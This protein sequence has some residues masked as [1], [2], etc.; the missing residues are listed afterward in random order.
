MDQTIPEPLP[1]V[2]NRSSCHPFTAHTSSMAQ[3]TARPSKGKNL[4]WWLSAGSP[5]PCRPVV[6]HCSTDGEG[7][8]LRLSLCTLGLTRN[9]I[10]T[11]S[12]AGKKEVMGARGEIWASR[13]KRI[14]LPATSPL[15]FLVHEAA[16]NHCSS[17]PPEACLLLQQQG[18]SIR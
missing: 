14:A 12:K 4:W 9:T 6:Y 13:S 10:G 18:V 2:R 15:P 17:H 3:Q 5:C 16:G 11:G 8:A 1:Q 7:Q